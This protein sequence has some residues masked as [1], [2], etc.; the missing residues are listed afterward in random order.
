MYRQLCGGEETLRTLA[1]GVRLHVSV[2]S[3]V[4]PQQV[5]K[6]ESFPTN[7]TRVPSPLVM[8]D[9][10]VLL[11]LFRPGE[12]AR[13]VSARVRLCIGMNTSMTSQQTPRLELLYA[14]TA[15]VAFVVVLHLY[16]AAQR[17][18]GIK[19]LT[20]HAAGKLLFAV[21]HRVV[22]QMRQSGE[23]S[24]ALLARMRA[25]VGRVEYSVL[26]QRTA[27]AETTLAKRT[28]VRLVAEVDVNVLPQA[29]RGGKCFL[30]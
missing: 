12:T 9:Q 20:A 22:S 21:C 2:S 28:S 27:V 18:F 30:A 16:M 5:D 15:A 14:I 25:R 7:V 24:V 1:A 29:V 19:T 23:P 17:Y 6:V 11:E 10:Q 26:A 8:A 4:Q 3:D 13:A